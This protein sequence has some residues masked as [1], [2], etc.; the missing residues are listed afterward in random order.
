MCTSVM[1]KKIYPVEQNLEENLPRACPCG[2]QELSWTARPKR[3]VGSSAS[4]AP[5]HMAG[6]TE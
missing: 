1:E 3:S 6:N 2:C 4:L 5:F